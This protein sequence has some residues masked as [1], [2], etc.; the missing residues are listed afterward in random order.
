V[1]AAPEGPLHIEICLEPPHA[2]LT[3]SGE[4]D[5]TNLVDLWDLTGVDTS[6]VL[7]IT[8]DLSDLRFV[9]G[10]GVTALTR[11]SDTQ[12]EAGRLVS[13]CGARPTTRKVLEIVGGA[14]YLEP[15][16]AL[17]S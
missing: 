2:K 7:M 10:A 14:E 16:L 3:L 11:Y 15:P 9:D 17:L 12:S 13:I 5:F 4:L 6:G 8:L 1:K